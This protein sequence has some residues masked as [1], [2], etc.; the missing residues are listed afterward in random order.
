MDIEDY[1]ENKDYI[2]RHINTSSVKELY[3]EI[4]DMICLA[5]EKGEI[6]L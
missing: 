3:D 1:E 5:F 4:F 2:I 6:L